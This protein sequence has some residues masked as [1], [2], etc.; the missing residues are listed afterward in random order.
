M[1]VGDF[2]LPRRDMVKVND[3]INSIIGSASGMISSVAM[4]PDVPLGSNLAP[5]VRAESILL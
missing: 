2:D 5:S 3:Q 4:A 1:S